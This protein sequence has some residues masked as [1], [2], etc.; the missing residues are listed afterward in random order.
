MPMLATRA[1]KTMIGREISG[2][3]DV[4]LMKFIR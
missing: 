3:R 1:N 2:F 4:Q